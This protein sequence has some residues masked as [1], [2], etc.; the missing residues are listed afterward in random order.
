MKYLYLLFAML[1]FS[2]CSKEEVYGPFKLKNGQEVEL[3]VDHRYGSANDNLLILPQNEVIGL[4]LH[5]FPERKP[6]YTYRVKAKFNI[7]L[8]PPQDASDRWFNFT[9]V[10]SEERYIGDESFDILLIKSY[11]PGGPF[12]DMGKI[13]DQYIYIK[14]KLEL[15][16]ASQTVKDQLEE[17][18]QHSLEMR[19]K[20][21]ET[22]QTPTP[23]WRSIKATV[24]HD[25][26]K[27]GKAYLVQH[28]E[29][30]LKN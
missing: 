9:K 1:F 8:N 23:K 26:T 30:T 28:I 5:G 7:N 12:I 25:L 18:W 16:Y 17:I 22:K 3:V 4:S 29:F 10:I 2:S 24:K 27:F 6:G 20:W 11:I 15:T 21:E 14:D 19:Q 13:D